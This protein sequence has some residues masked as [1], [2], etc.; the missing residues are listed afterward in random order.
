MR[1][2]G[3]C[4]PLLLGRWLLNI[5]G[6][7]ILDGILPG[8]SDW[9]HHKR[10]RLLLC[11]LHELLLVTESDAWV[12]VHLGEVTEPLDGFFLQHLELALGRHVVVSVEDGVGRL[13]RVAVV[14]GLKRIVEEDSVVLDPGLLAVDVLLL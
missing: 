12:R 6:T 3:P 10:L 1:P 8:C 9:R 14:Q 5:N 11:L 4:R 2:L 7:V 13:E